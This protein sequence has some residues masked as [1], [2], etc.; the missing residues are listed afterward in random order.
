MLLL[1]LFFLFLYL[2]FLILLLSSSSFLFPFLL[3]LHH[4]FCISDNNFF[5]TSFS[6]FFLLSFLFRLLLIVFTLF[7][8]YGNLITQTMSGM[9][10]DVDSWSETVNN[11]WKL[12]WTFKFTQKMWTIMST[13]FWKFVEQFN[14][15]PENV[16]NLWTIMSTINTF[17]TK[18]QPMLFN[19]WMVVCTPKH[20]TQNSTPIFFY[21]W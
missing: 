2:I 15:Y 18:Q 1:L 3:L 10:E 14:S 7:Q 19:L 5:P 8:I 16:K 13:I 21:K 20:E 17:I 9:F 12:G 11:S 6:H 4:D